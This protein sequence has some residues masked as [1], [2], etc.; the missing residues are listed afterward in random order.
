MTLHRIWISLCSGLIVAGAVR[1]QQPVSLF[2]GQTLK[3]WKAITCEA[4]VVDGAILIKSGNGILLAEKQ[5]GDFVFECDWKAL[6]TNMWDSGI[7]FRA[8]MPVSEKFPWPKQ[9]QINL[10]RGQEGAIGGADREKAASLFKK[11]EWN[12][13]K[14]TVKGATAELE[15]NGE[16]AWTR[17]GIEPAK[18]NL[19]LQA[20]V[21]GGGQFLFRN[22]TI[23]ELDAPAP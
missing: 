15:F 18:G 7:Y 10:R 16:K 8:G 19:C 12:H 14:L 6:N 9:H 13:F 3:G 2:D 11:G 5:Y 23:V 17:E 22:L 20:E 21:P 4:E 1:A